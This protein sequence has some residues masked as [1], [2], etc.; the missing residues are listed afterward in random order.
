M[1]NR[2][3]MNYQDKWR[4]FL[5]KALRQIEF[6]NKTV[7]EDAVEE[8]SYQVEYIHLSKDEYL[9]KSGTVCREIYIISHG[10]IEIQ[11]SNKRASHY[12]YLDTLHSGANIGTCSMLTGEEYTISGKA[13]NE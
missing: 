12:T 8:I 3:K 7:T 4:Q 5:K 9:F 6:L 10:D 13:L 11:I 1:E 2:I